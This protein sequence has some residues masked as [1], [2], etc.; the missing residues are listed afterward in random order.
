[1]TAAATPLGVGIVGCGQVAS[2]LHAP[3]LR[4]VE[5]ARLVAVADVD[6]ARARALAARE[7]VAAVYEDAA[8][9]AADPAVD[10]VAVCVPPRWHADVALAALDA[11][12]TCSSRSRSPRRS[13]TRTRSSPTRRSTT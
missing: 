12:G 3:A 1:M 7:G 4:A 11:G 9:L 10:L 13:T 5:G 8:A 2:E 6:A